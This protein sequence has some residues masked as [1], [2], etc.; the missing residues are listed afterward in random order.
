MENTKMM[1][2]SACLI[3]MI[4]G[5]TQEEPVANAT[6][7]SNNTTPLLGHT[8]GPLIS[9][10]LS[11]PITAVYDYNCS[12]KFYDYWWDYPYANNYN[13]LLNHFYNFCPIY[14]Y[15][16]Y[17]YNCSPKFY[18]YWSDHDHP[19]ANNYNQLHNCFYNCCPVYDYN[20]SPKF[21]DYWWDYP[22]ANNYNQ[23]LNHFYNFFP[24]YDYNCTP[25]FYD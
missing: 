19:Y 14:D 24:I 8:S 10:N 20:C 11:A 23:L 3:F 9:N 15:N 22:Y 1:V 2:L 18:D 21:Y 7:T 12:P 6:V 17:D 5:C 16:F 25:K 4:R 13:Q